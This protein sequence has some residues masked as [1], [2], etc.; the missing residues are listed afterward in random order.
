MIIETLHCGDN[1]EYMKT[2]PSD[3]I[4]L[5]YGDILYGTGRDFVD[6]KDIKADRKTVEEFYIP[7]I[8]EMHRLLKP[9]GSIYLQMDTRINHYVR[10]ILEGIFGIDNFRNEIVWKKRAV[11]NNIPTSYFTKNKDHIIYFVKTKNYCF[12]TQYLKLSNESIKRHFLKDKKGFYCLESIKRKNNTFKT[13]IFNGKKYNFNSIWT[14]ETLDN[15]IKNGYII[16]ENSLG[17]LAYRKYL[18]DRKGVQ[19]NDFWEDLINQFTDT[20]YQTQ[21][22]IDLMARI[23]KASSNEGD[24]IADF[25][26]G[27]GSFLVAGKKLN[28]NVIGC[29]INPKAIE[30]SKARL[31]KCNDLFNSI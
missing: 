9:T 19:C 26:C 25:F 10:L 7:R 5:I 13:L 16:E 8:T 20:D 18:N 3:S 27:S 12:N 6:Y 21:K 24:T 29:D 23:I 1:L 28:R 2:L 14:Q 17:D 30:L 4:H 11:A 31:Y 15:N 22:S